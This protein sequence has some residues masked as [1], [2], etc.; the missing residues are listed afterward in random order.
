MIYFSAGVKKFFHENRIRIFWSVLLG[1]ASTFFFISW[2]TPLLLNGKDFSGRSLPIQI[3][4]LVGTWILAFLILYFILWLS[5]KIVQNQ[6]VQRNIT[7]LLD[8]LNAIK[9]IQLAGA[10]ITIGLLLL[11]LILH[12]RLVFFPY[13]MEF[14]EGA[15]VLTTEAF[16]K[17][18]NPWA[19]ENNLTYINV[20]GIVYNAL[21]FPFAAILGNSLW[22]HRLISFLAVIGQLVLVVRVMRLSGISWL[23]TGF[24]AVFLWLGQ[25]YYT[26]PMA[27]PDTLGQF[28]FLLTILLPLL[29]NYS[30]KSL[31]LSLLFGWLGFFTKPYFVLGLPLVAVYLFLFKNKLRAIGYAFAG[32]LLIALSSL[33]VNNFF[34]AYFLNVVFSHI[35]DTNSIY[36]FLVYQTIRYLGEYWSV[37]LVAFIAVITSAAGVRFGKIEKF[38]VDFNLQKPLLSFKLDILLFCLLIS[39]VLIFASLGRHNGTRMAYYYQLISP[40]LI[41]LVFGILTRHPQARGAAIICVSIN[42]IFHA[43]GNLKPD[44]QPWPVDYWQKIQSSLQ[45]SREVIHSP[46][47]TYE[48]MKAGMPVMNSGQT[49]YFYPYPQRDFFLYPPKEKIQEIGDEFFATLA[50]RIANREYD[51]ILVDDPYPAF[52][53]RRYYE[54]YYSPGEVITISMPHTEQIW[55][56]RL[57][58][59]RLEEVPV[60]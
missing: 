27:R 55:P 19:L 51:I 24:A 39:C 35:A 41:I 58:T 13:Q 15:I 59:P 43:Y 26:T 9:P 12:L 54:T 28:F 46:A 23:Y 34:E 18:I 6:K 44:L 48:V 50:Q 20:Y 3:L 33:V 60:P 21:V 36:E 7:R 42:L 49:S 52:A 29:G 17:G 22:I 32:V 2:I 5:E 25:I 14:R 37:L 30:T 31:I 38:P 56:I 57:M 16:L 4:L 1:L 47:I 45:Q 53:K 10:V 40:F 11:L 8:F